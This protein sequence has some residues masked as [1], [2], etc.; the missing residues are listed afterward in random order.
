MEI[1]FHV[2]IG[3]LAE[4]QGNFNLFI[5]WKLKYDLKSFFF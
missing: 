4:L 5:S 2:A 3:W 1:R